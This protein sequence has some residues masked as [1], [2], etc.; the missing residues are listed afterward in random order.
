MGDFG[1]NITPTNID[2]TLT[3]ETAFYNPPG[4]EI[5]VTSLEVF[6]FLKL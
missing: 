5:T 4:Y 6:S 2:L 1:L 3:S